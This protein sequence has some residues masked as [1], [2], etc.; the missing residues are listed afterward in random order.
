LIRVV[1]SYRAINQPTPEG[2]WL[3]E[4]AAEPIS[5]HSRNPMLRFF[6]LFPLSALL[7][8]PA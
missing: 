6:F 8:Q 3:F 5:G 1:F 7:Y 2:I 4:E